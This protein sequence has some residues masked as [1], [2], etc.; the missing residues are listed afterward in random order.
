MATAAFLL[1]NAASVRASALAVPSR[2]FLRD[3][4][5][6]MGRTV[7][8]ILT[9]D[10]PNGKG[11]N[12]DVVTV[13]AGYARNYLV[14]EKMALY[15][16]PENFERLG[17][18]DPDK[19]TVEERRARQIRETAEAGDEDLRA[20][21]LLRHYLRNKVLKIWRNADTSTGVVSPGNVTST[22]V[23]DKLSKQLKIDLEDHELVHLR[24]QPVVGF[25]EI[26]SEQIESM[27]DDIGTVNEDGKI[28]D[29]KVE[30]RQL[31]EYLAK[32]S[33]GGGYSV[34]LKIAVAKR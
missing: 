5:R 15:A 3:S 27:L 32:I 12:G 11:Y 25:S 19:E 21:D 18:S 8:I 2:S 17:M 26:E 4:R 29:C 24:A 34:P 31:G 23:R 28:D 20:A 10:L 33:L 6:S 16:I 1:R 14:P 30:I 13:K 22:N 7:R 9:D